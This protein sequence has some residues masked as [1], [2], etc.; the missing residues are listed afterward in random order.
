[1]KTYHLEDFKSNV[2]KISLYLAIIIA[3][4]FFALRGFNVL[5][6]TPVATLNTGVLLLSLIIIYIC[7]IKCQEKF[8]YIQTVFYF[9]IVTYIFVQI[10]IEPDNV[11][12]PIWVDFTLIVAYVTTD[13]KIAIILNI[14]AFIFLIFLKLLGYYKADDYSFLTLM[15]SMFSFSLL[16]GLISIQLDKYNK[17]M[18]NQ[19]EKL[20][21]LALIDEL[22]QIFNRRAF[23]QIAQKQLKQAKRE[24]KNL[25]IIAM[26]IDY[27]KKINDTYGHEGG[28]IVLK[29]F[30][31]NIKE[32]IR[33]NDLFARIGGEE[34]VLLL[35]D[36]SEEDIDKIIEKILQKIRHTPIHI[37]HEK[38]NITVSIGAYYLR[39]YEVDNIQKALKNAD[40]ALYIAK[41]TGRNRVVYY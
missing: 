25:C 4:V 7:F 17:E 23:Y 15:I 9:I 28:D 20:E 32:I 19:K 1:M 13:K 35:Y 14:Y 12:I 2:T 11:T 37:D 30:V 31:E 39:Y 24:K 16:G 21:Q 36:V 27:F 3:G 33:E 18:L 26:D 10:I 22:T 40:K 29:E 5:E 38:I 34:F 8:K 41:R 6:P